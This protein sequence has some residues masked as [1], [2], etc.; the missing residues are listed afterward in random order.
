MA[1]TGQEWAQVFKKYNSGTY[2]NQWTIV[3]YNLFV[4]GLPLPK[5]G[6]LYVLEQLP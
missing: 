6:L 5:K 1:R 2:N 3:N 4:P